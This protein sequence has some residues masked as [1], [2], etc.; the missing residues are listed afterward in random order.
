MQKLQEVKA[1][2]FPFVEERIYIGH[3]KCVDVVAFVLCTQFNLI[4]AHVF[5]ASVLNYKLCH[6]SFKYRC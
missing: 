3:S 6:I 2:I 5:V 1:R 4:V